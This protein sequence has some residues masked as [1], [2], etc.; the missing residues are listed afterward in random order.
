MATAILTQR[1]T[2]FPQFIV[3]KIG[4]HH[5]TVHNIKHILYMHIFLKT[6]DGEGHLKIN[7]VSAP[8]AVTL[9]QCIRLSCAAL[10]II[11]HIFPV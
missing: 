4:G 10:T 5:I 7:A 3:C 11:S 1:P 6:E 9:T 8:P 2:I